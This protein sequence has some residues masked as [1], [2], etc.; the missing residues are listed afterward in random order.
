MRISEERRQTMLVVAAFL[1]LICFFSSFL[2][3]AYALHIKITI[4]KR[5]ALIQTYN[6]DVLPGIFVAV[7]II[8]LIQNIVAIFILLRLRYPQERES[9]LPLLVAVLV[10]G[11]LLV[12]F[13]VVSAI[14]S[15]VHIGILEDEFHKGI[16][17]AMDELS[18]YLYVL[19]EELKNE[20]DGVQLDYECCGDRAYTDWFQHAWLAS[21]LI[22]VVPGSLK[23]FTHIS[24]TSPRFTHI[25]VT[26]PRYTQDGDNYFVDDVPFS[27]CDVRAPRPC[28]HHHVHD[29]NLHFFYNHLRETT[30]HVTGCRYIL[31]NIYGTILLTVGWVAVSIA[32]IKTFTLLMVRLLQTSLFQAQELGDWKATTEGYLYYAARATDAGTGS[33]IGD[34]V[35]ANTTA[36]FESDFSQNADSGSASTSLSDSSGSN[37]SN[38]SNDSN[39][40]S[41]NNNDTSDSSCSD[42]SDSSHSDSSSWEDM[43]STDSDESNTSEAEAISHRHTRS[44]RLDKQESFKVDTLK[45]CASTDS[46]IGEL[47][48]NKKMP[49]PGYLDPLEETEREWCHR[50]DTK[51]IHGPYKSNY[52][53]LLP[54]QHWQAG[55]KR[56]DAHNSGGKSEDHSHRDQRDQ[57]MSQGPLSNLRRRPKAHLEDEH[58]TNLSADTDHGLLS[59]I[60][61]H[62]TGTS[63]GPSF[64]GLGGLFSSGHKYSRVSE[65][66]PEWEAIS[67]KNINAESSDRTKRKKKKTSVNSGFQKDAERLPAP[68][69]TTD[70]VNEESTPGRSNSLKGNSMRNSF[71][72][73]G[74]VGFISNNQSP[75]VSNI[76]TSPGY[77]YVDMANRDQS[78]S[79]PTQGVQ[80]AQPESRVT[81]FA[82]GRLGYDLHAQIDE[83]SLQNR[84][85][86]I[87]NVNKHGSQSTTPSI[88]EM[89]CGTNSYSKA[90]LTRINIH[91][92][93]KLTKK[94]C[95]QVNSTERDRES[96]RCSTIRARCA[97]PHPG[98][99]ASPLQTSS[100][101]SEYDLIPTSMRPSGHP[102]LGNQESSVGSPG[103]SLVPASDL[104]NEVAEI[105]TG[106]SSLASYSSTAHSDVHVP[107]PLYSNTKRLSKLAPF[108]VSK[109]AGLHVGLSPA[110]TDPQSFFSSPFSLSDTASQVTL[111]SS[112]QVSAPKLKQSPHN[113]SGS[114]KDLGRRSHIRS[115]K[116]RSLSK[117]VSPLTPPID[118]MPE[119]LALG[120]GRSLGNQGCMTAESVPCLPSD[121]SLLSSTGSTS[122][123]LV[124]TESNAQS[125]PHEER[126]LLDAIGVAEAT[127]TSR[128]PLYGNSNISSLMQINSDTSNSTATLNGPRFT[129]DEHQ[130]KTSVRKDLEEKGHAEE[131]CSSVKENL[132]PTYRKG[133][134]SPFY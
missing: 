44:H 108:G 9:R 91:A 11:I 83:S 106:S 34:A 26:S 81:N 1:A 14:V 103:S 15:F 64:Q 129:E 39:D 47:R 41:D 30:I 23:K 90:M 27:C 109:R 67:N 45:A 55:D 20:I 86:F 99:T 111:S 115:C 97:T 84:N 4:D 131:N 82:I 51:T 59:R 87:S 95:F 114:P 66:E 124:H 18:N 35:S 32:V 77:Q 52:D 76:I 71:R 42:S 33:E 134:V 93:R 128:N 40:S 75:G 120:P 96:S 116:R 119:S 113:A 38:D 28:I 101:L 13:E 70:F 94:V 58:R 72:T 69:Q 100:D 126:C 19:G 107:S 73:N 49:E 37:N 36:E 12:I 10:G 46:R 63:S 31:M 89:N 123:S 2:L 68:N 78:D 125:V 102:S 112:A 3:F 22:R 133:M 61:E 127:E 132:A 5:T 105:I 57:F 62:L 85:T 7:G 60:K 74:Q 53:S 56:N 98:I 43:D 24:V 25:S 21:D 110:I 65:F 48:V 80:N 130:H 8:N 104:D 121:F 88:N 54:A 79:D 16:E 92:D 50:N 117:S 122:A 29:D 6:S 17:K 118:L